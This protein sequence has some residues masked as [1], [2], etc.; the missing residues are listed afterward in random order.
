VCVRG[1]VVGWGEVGWWDGMGW[2]EVEVSID[3][4]VYMCGFVVYLRG[5][6]GGT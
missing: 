4:D 6:Y 5:F 1:G 3:G 2:I